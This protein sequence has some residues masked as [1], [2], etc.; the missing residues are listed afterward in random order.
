MEKSYLC[1]L[2]SIRF[3]PGVNQDEFFS[4]AVTGP[5]YSGAG[6]LQQRH[7]ISGGA[8]QQIPEK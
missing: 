8:C 7:S 5:L 3:S 2:L 1:S 6:L 4:W